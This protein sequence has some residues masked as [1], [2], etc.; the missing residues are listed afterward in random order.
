MSLSSPMK[1]TVLSSLH[2]LNV[3]G[4][5]KKPCDGFGRISISVMVNRAPQE[6]VIQKLSTTGTTGAEAPNLPTMVDLP[7]LSTSIGFSNLPPP[8]PPDPPDLGSVPPIYT[9]KLH[10]HRDL[11]AH[12]HHRRVL[13]SIL[14]PWSRSRSETSNSIIEEAVEPH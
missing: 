8:Q 11:A 3:S 7:C 10:H 1:S 2:R 6:P 9:S 12:H 4:E 5:R 13:P 14:H